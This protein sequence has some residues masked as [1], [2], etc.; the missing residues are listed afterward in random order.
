MLVKVGHGLDVVSLKL[1]LG[2]LINP[3]GHHLTEDLTACFAPD[4]IGYDT[5]GILWL[6]ETKEQRALRDRRI[7]NRTVCCGSDGLA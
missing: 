3:S 6:N 5:N 2:D 7:D 4:G 1:A